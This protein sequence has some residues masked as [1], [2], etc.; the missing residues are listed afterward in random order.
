[1]KL[2]EIALVMMT[3]LSIFKIFTNHQY[4]VVGFLLLKTI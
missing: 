4:P 1:M 2:R 3:I